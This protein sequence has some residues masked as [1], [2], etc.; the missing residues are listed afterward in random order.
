MKD[1]AQENPSSPLTAWLFGALLLALYVPVVAQTSRR[2]FQAEQYAHGVFIFPLA[3]LLLW[4]RRDAIR[5]APR[6]TCGWGLL[7]LALGL[8]MQGIGHTL[9]IEFVAM[10]SLLPT[11][12]GGILLLYGPT[13]WHTVRFPILFLGF[14]ANLP[15]FVLDGLSHALQEIS[16]TGR[17]PA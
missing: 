2:W 17:R 8:L 12:A 16:A 14:A 11:L 6:Q 7:P 3:A 1:A 9:K 5:A 13:L 15:G 4:C 10:L